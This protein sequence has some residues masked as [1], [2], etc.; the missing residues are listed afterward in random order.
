MYRRVDEGNGYDDE[1]MRFSWLL[2]SCYDIVLAIIQFFFSPHYM[3]VFFL[4]IPDQF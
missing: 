4:H 2:I 3:L 1:V